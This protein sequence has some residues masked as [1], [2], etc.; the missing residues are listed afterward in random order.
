MKNIG[1]T[2]EN[3]WFRV[4]WYGKCMIFISFSKE[5]HRFRVSWDGKTLVLLRKTKSL[6][7]LDLVRVRFGVEGSYIHLIV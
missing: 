2:K 5:N 3:Q 6:G 7:F 1:F 4:S